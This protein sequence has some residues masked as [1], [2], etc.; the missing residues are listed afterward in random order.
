MFSCYRGWKEACQATRA[1]STTSRRELLSSF[2]YL[3]GK[4]PK[5]IHAILRL[6]SRRNWPTWASNVFIIHPILRIWPRRTAACSLDWKKQLKV[7]H[8]SSEA[9]VIAAAETWLD[10][11]TS[12]FFWVAYKS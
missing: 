8:F 12:E 7:R 3:Q 4:A 1:F 10:G 11:Q 6:Q 2:F 5:E 9:K